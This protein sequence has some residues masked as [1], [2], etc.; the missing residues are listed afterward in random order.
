MA[1]APVKTMFDYGVTQGADKI[2]P[3]NLLLS[4]KVQLAPQV[5]GDLE[6]IKY[7]GRWK[8]IDGRKSEHD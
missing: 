5:T 1:G 4:V 6:A 3:K 7:H 8:N 2:S